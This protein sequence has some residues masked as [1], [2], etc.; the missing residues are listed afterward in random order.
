MSHSLMG[1]QN[2]INAEVGRSDSS[3][4][5]Y[6]AS[7]PPQ[8]LDA[9]GQHA[10]TI[11]LATEHIA[12]A[13]GMNHYEILLEALKEGLETYQAATPDELKR[14]TD[15]VLTAAKEAASTFELE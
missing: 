15:S 3:H 10:V 12:D 13:S 1:L 6:N 4:P 5:V 7:L 14:I 11:W 9:I 2:Q 8:Y